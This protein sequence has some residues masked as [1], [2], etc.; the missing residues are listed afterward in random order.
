MAIGEQADN[1]PFNEVF[2][3]NDDLIDFVKQ[4]LNEPGCRLNFGVDGSGRPSAACARVH[5]RICAPIGRRFKSYSS[6]LSG[7]ASPA[8]TAARRGASSMVSPKPWLRP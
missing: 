6:R 3:A 4:R 8:I 5:S 7:A 1:Q 2:L